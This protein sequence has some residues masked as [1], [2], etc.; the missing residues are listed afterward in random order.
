MLNYFSLSLP[1]FRPPSLPPAQ[2]DS[3]DRCANG[4][5]LLLQCNL[6][7]HH[8]QLAEQAMVELHGV[9]DKAVE[10]CGSYSLE[11]DSSIVY[12]APL[13]SLFVSAHDYSLFSTRKWF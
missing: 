4:W 10:A 7:P 8:A 3:G 2:W 13:S 9:L 5:R 6:A 12:R 11:L 1:P